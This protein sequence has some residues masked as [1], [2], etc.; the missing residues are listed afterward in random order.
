[1][2]V[3]SR[4][5]SPSKRRGRGS[6]CGSGVGTGP[7]GWGEQQGVSVAHPRVGATRSSGR[8]EAARQEVRGPGA[9]SLVGGEAKGPFLQ[10][11][12]VAG[13]GFG[14]SA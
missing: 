5:H 12:P 6:P 3:G 13:S 4:G 7:V 1:M 8:E 2:T 11:L 9:G 14:G 10:G